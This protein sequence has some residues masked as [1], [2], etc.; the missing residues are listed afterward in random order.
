[1]IQ[2]NSN[3]PDPEPIKHSLLPVLALLP[4][5]IPE[6]FRDWVTDIA[7]RM[8]CPVDFI[9]VA[10]IVAAAALVGAGG[11]GKPKKKRGLASGSESL[12]RRCWPPR[13]AENASHIGSDAFYQ[14]AGSGGKAGL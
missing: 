9:A 10:A 7:E 8:Q 6:P 1:M 5:N 12:G 3:W 2:A 4:T 14:C 11:G 13:D